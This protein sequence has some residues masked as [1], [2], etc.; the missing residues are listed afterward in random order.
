[1]LSVS[2]QQACM[3]VYGAAFY[4]RCVLFQPAFPHRHVSLCRGSLSSYMKVVPSIA[5]VRFC[6]ETIIQVMG[7]GGVRRYRTQEQG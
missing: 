6:Y 7:V 5:A 1:M 4:A 2:L 3:H